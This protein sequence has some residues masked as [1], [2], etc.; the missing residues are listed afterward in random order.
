MAKVKVNQELVKSS[1]AFE[2]VDISVADYTFANA[3]RG[4]YVGGSGDVIVRGVGD[5]ADATFKNVPAGTTLPI[6][7]AKIVRT[8]TT[9]TFMI[10]LI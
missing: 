1:P 6:Q 4:V 10:G 7:P 5:D 3:I 2:A 9:A 8:G